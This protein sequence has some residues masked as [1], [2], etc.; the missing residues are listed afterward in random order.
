ML[1]NSVLFE[2][3]KEY[4]EAR[5]VSVTEG[6]KLGYG[7]WR[8]PQMRSNA[9]AEWR[10]RFESHWEQVAGAMFA[11][12]RHGIYYVDPRP[13]NINTEGLAH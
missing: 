13:S 8:D 2:R 11:L 5:G 10:E 7:Y 12:E 4:A 1:N 3:V 9:Y 6:A